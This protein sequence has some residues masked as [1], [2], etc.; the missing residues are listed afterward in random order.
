MTHSLHRSGTEQSL[1]HDFVVLALGGRKTFRERL[2]AGLAKRSPRFLDLLRRLY[3]IAT[4]RKARGSPD[5]AEATAP[6]WAAAFHAREDLCRYLRALKASGDGRSVVVSGLFDVLE[7]CFREL[8]L[9]PHT[10]QYSLG[11][12]GKTGDLPDA[13]ILDVTTMCGHHLVSP[14][15]V[16]HL[17]HIIRRGEM[18]PEAAAEAMSGFCLCGIFNRQRAAGLMEG[19]AGRK[20]GDE[21]RS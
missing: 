13:R 20:C 6:G 11:R 8:D 5:G 18:T 3:R 2:C 4:F 15:Y 7:A 14:A 21:D 16:K 17:A 19:L 9:R 1:R 10:V 12:F